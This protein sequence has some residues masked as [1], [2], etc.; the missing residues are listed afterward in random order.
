M[1]T[2]FGHAGKQMTRVYRESCLGRNDRRE[3]NCIGKQKQLKGKG[4]ETYWDR[5]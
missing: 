2:G 3:R 4:K 5:E 1:S